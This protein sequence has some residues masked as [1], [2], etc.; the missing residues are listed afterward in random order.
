MYGVHARG[1]QINN[2]TNGQHEGKKE[3]NGANE[4]K[5]KDT[6]ECE[7][8]ARKAQ[9]TNARNKHQKK[10]RKSKNTTKRIV[11]PNIIYN[12]NLNHKKKQIAMPKVQLK[13]RGDTKKNLQKTKCAKMSS[14]RTKMNESICKTITKNEASRQLNI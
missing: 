10:G 14:L 7:I 13:R 11:S 5:I 12:L 9:N 6:T 4:I 1:V 3:N 2:D 8:V